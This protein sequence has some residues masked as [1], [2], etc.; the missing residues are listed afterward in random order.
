MSLEGNMAQAVRYLNEIDN[1]L[2][3][4]NLK[5]KTYLDRTSPPTPASTPTVTTVLGN[6]DFTVYCSWCMG[7]VE[8]NCGELVHR[9]RHEVLCEACAPCDE[10]S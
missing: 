4:I 5:L 7:E 6:I 10:C 3:S 1:N 8:T 9:C 2:E